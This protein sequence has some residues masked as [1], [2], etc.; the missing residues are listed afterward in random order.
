MSERLDPRIRSNWEKID[1]LL[2]I[3]KKKYDEQIFR[4]L[5]GLYEDIGL[6]TTR[7]WERENVEEQIRWLQQLRKNEKSRAK[8]NNYGELERRETSPNESMSIGAHKSDLNIPEVTYDDIGGLKNEI[9]EIREVIELPLRYPEI[10]KR[11]GIDPPR[12]V[13]LH[14]P[15]GCGKTLLARAVAN[16]SEASFFVI[17]GPEVMSKY[18]GESEKILREVFQEAEKKAPSIIFIDEIDAIAPKRVQVNG[19]VEKRLVAQL[20]VL[21]DGMQKRGQIIIIGATNIPDALD[22]ALRRPG[23]FDRETEIRLPDYEGRVEI[24]RVYTTRMPLT[25]DADLQAIAEETDG[26]SGAQLEAV[27]REAAYNTIRRH[28][29]ILINSDGEI[30]VEALKNLVVTMEDFLM[31]VDKVSRGALTAQNNG[32]RV[33]WDE[34]VKEARRQQKER[35]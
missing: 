18:Y 1:K 28:K 33:S 5:I 15:S 17:N 25:K 12:G 13:L 21:M 4:K 6:H 26:F 20:L 14:G 31:A 10:F 2:P 8:E 9:N 29:P 22:P 30:S 34:F 35:N 7:T 27:C 24:L 19:E 23:R 3:V 32:M 16:E 11:L